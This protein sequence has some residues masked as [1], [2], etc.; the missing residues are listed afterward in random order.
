M[1]QV[2]NT[3]MLPLVPVAEALTGAANSAADLGQPIEDIETLRKKNDELEHTVAEMQIEIVRLREIEQDYQRLSELVD[4]A[5]QHS[6]QVLVTA[7]VVAIDTSSYLRWII[8]NR[9]AQDG[10]NIGNPVISNLGL[11]GRVE[12]VA[13]NSA[14][15]RL[16]I[17]PSS[18][19][20]AR[21]QNDQTEGTISGQLQGGLLM[22][23]IPQDTVVQ[24][25]DPVLTSGLGGTFP[26]GIVIGQVESVIRQPAALFQ[27]AGVR[28]SVNFDDLQIVSVIIDFE[29]VD[30]SIFDEN[31]N[32][33]NQP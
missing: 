8:I 6:N 31:L 11:V 19:I 25:G 3:L 9:G 27:Q 4:Y 7:D 22:D 17:D 24:V 5:L 20:N 26:A 13:A 32:P 23:L 10:I 15:I 30:L 14:W 2:I 28:P 1:R 21:L 12:D 29:P 16:A 33:D 18:I